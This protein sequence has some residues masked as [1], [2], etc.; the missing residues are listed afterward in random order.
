MSRTDPVRGFPGKWDPWWL[1]DDEGD[2]SKCASLVWTELTRIESLESYRRECDRLFAR[3]Y[4]DPR[5]AGFSTVGPAYPS[6]D[7]LDESRSSENVIREVV[8]TLHNKFAKNKPVPTVVT[9]GATYTEQQD[10]EE[11][12][13]WIQGVFQEDN[14]YDLLA[15]AQFH[16]MTICDG[17][18]G[19]RDDYD[20]GRPVAYVIPPY[21][22]HVDPIDAQYQT[23]RAVYLVR[24]EAREVMAARYPEFADEIWNTSNFY[25]EYYSIRLTAYDQ[26]QMNYIECW[27]LPSKPGAEDGKH[28]IGTKQCAF[29]NEQWDEQYFPFVKL[30]WVP[31]VIGY[32]STGLIEDL[33][34]PQR[35]LNKVRM[36]KDEHLRLLSNSFYS[37]KRGAN[38]IVSHLSNLIGRVIETSDEPPVLHVPQPISPDLWKSEETLR[39]Q[40][41]T[42]SGVSQ[43]AVNN[44][45]PAGIDSG[46]A[47]RVYA[48][49]QDERYANAYISKEKAVVDLANL[50]CKRAQ[51]M[52]ESDDKAELKVKISK[53][54]LLT[55][56]TWKDTDLDSFKVE[57]E[58]ASALS[59]TLAGKFQDIEDMMAL[60]LIKSDDQKRRLLQMPDL[61]ADNDLSL[62]PYNLI[63]KTLQD[64]IL[65]RGEAVSPEPYWDLGTCSQLGVQVLCYAQLKGYPESRLQLLRNWVSEC[66][67]RLSPPEPPAPEAPPVGPPGV[68]PPGVAPPGGPSAPPELPPAPAGPPPPVGPIAG[69]PVP[70]GQS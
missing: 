20:L 45:K 15:T 66:A 44:Q 9:T 7:I 52:L 47:L 67:A 68:A 14:V 40:I 10:A 46:K 18:V 64:R 53:S 51:A 26:R 49:M 48:D 12:E 29:V 24:T 61:E 36:A 50:Y 30:P 19:V 63:L 32:F 33:I 16:S 17:F 21:E 56:V 11:R 4:G 59:K 1:Y 41:Y 23:P 69:M 38:I 22:V 39:S 13:Q 34:P 3:Y 60:G 5:Y 37:V 62:A 54:S 58:A 42:Q 6:P 8:S 25:E 28:F 2:A 70:T 43:S 57:V 55:T 65:K 27:H 31:R 35:Q